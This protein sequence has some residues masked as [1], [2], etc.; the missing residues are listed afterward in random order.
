[1]Y[2]FGQKYTSKEKFIM[3]LACVL[4]STGAGVAIPCIIDF[5]NPQDVNNASPKEA[6]LLFVYLVSYMMVAYVLFL[7]IVRFIT[8]RV[9]FLYNYIKSKLL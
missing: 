2:L 9:I 3:G 8:D 7:Y 1:M 4:M 5:I 6:G